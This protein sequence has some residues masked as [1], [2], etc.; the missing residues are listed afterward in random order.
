MTHHP[1]FPHID[2]GSMG[3]MAED[4]SKRDEGCSRC[5]RRSDSVTVEELGRWIVEVDSTLLCTECS[6]EGK[7]EGGGQLA[8]G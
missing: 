1:P 5:G 4:D 7:E 6:T 8:T 3:C 2:A